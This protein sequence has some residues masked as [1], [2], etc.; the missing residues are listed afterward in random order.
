MIAADQIESLLRQHPGDAEQTACPV[1]YRRLLSDTAWDNYDLHSLLALREIGP[2]EREFGF[3]LRHYWIPA[4]E[5]DYRQAWRLTLPDGAVHHGGCDI[6][7]AMARCRSNE[8]LWRETIRWPVSAEH[9]AADSV[10]SELL[11]SYDCYD[12]T[13]ASARPIA[14]APPAA[15]QKVE[16]RRQALYRLPMLVPPGPV[17]LGFA[18][19]ARVG[20]DYMNFRLETEEQIGTTPVLVIRR[21]GRYT[22]RLARETAGTNGGHEPMSIVTERKGVTITATNRCAILE[23]RVWERVVEASG[24]TAGCVGVT[25]EIIT[26][27]IRSRPPD[28]DSNIPRGQTAATV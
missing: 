21:E 25:N 12:Q 16:A 8:C 7:R 28:S 11:C 22:V 5:L 13:Y 10:L 2:T 9:N 18:W 14:F 4:T 6:H 15:E 1:E 27:L 26:R 17:P 3:L 24:A 20:D 19:Y 23:D